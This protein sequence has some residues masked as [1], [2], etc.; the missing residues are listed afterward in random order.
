VATGVGFWLPRSSSF[1]STPL[2]R[3]EA[4]SSSSTFGFEDVVLSVFRPWRV[5]LTSP[6]AFSAP[7]SVM[8]V[9]ICFGVRPNC[10]PRSRTSAFD[11]RA[12]GVSILVCTDFGSVPSMWCSSLPEMPAFSAAKRSCSKFSAALWTGCIELSRC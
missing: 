12:P 2:I 5:F 10:L 7:T 9:L 3:F 8:M 4:W 1:L 11:F 6:W